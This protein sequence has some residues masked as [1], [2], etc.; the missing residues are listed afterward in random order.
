[1]SVSK[2]RRGWGV[3]VV[4]ASES[5]LGAIYGGCWKMGRPVKGRREENFL[6]E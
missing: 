4:K 3:G 2:R 1:M 6:I 5:F